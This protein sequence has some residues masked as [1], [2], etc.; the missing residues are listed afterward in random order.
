MK[1][2]ILPKSKLK[3]EFHPKVKVT[4]LP[5]PKTESNYD[6]LIPARVAAYEEAKYERESEVLFKAIESAANELAL[7]RLFST[8][9]RPALILALDCV[10]SAML[11]NIVEHLTD[12]YEVASHF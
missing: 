1:D 2:I 3:I 12:G 6:F 4:K 11:K 8:A 9:S 5:A 7:H 10:A